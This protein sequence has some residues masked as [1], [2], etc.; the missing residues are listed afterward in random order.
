MA[1]EVW[2][3]L[4]TVGCIWYLDQCQTNS[5]LIRVFVRYSDLDFSFWLTAG[6]PNLQESFRGQPMHC[7]HVGSPVPARTLE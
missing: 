2:A 5:E 6:V 7:E 3:N 1:H 4:I